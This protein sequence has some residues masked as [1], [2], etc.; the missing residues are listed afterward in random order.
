MVISLPTSNHR[1]RYIWH[2]CITITKQDVSEFC[3]MV[4]VSQNSRTIL[5]YRTYSDGAD[6]SSH[7]HAF[8]LCTSPTCRQCELKNCHV[9]Q[10]WRIS[11][12][13]LKWESAIFCGGSGIL[14]CIESAGR[15]HARCWLQFIHHD[16]TY[17]GLLNHD[18]QSTDKGTRTDFT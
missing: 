15:D 9:I 10:Q 18:V 16:G 4:F 8:I 1:L 3:T 11:S 12:G 17:S 2:S 13:I 7:H 14:Q 5:S 6:M